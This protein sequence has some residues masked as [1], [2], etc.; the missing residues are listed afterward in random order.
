[1]SRELAALSSHGVLPNQVVDAGMR[2][3]LARMRHVVL[4][5]YV[6][7]IAAVLVARALHV[8]RKART[9]QISLESALFPPE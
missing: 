1:M 8:Q 2:I 4:A 6:G 9:K 3:A 5:T 7:L